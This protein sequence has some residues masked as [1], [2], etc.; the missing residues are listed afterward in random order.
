MI[1][2]SKS[3]VTA[4]LLLSMADDAMAKTM[5]YGMMSGKSPTP[6]NMTDFEKTVS[7]VKWNGR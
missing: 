6:A 5:G 1:F 2:L 4:L 3:C 7:E